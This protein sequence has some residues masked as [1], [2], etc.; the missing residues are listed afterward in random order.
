MEMKI[1]ERPNGSRSG[2]ASLSNIG[3][4]LFEVNLER[5]VV[6]ILN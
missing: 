4:G 1:L 6:L 3:Y 5:E 2:F